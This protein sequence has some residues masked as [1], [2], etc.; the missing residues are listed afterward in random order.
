MS[1]MDM[2]RPEIALRE[3]QRVL[4]PGGLVQFSIVHPCFGPPYRKLLRDADRRP[5]ALE[6]G[7]Y[8]DTEDRI[9]EWI[10]GETPPEVRAGL[11]RFRVPLFHKPISFWFNAIVDAGLSIERVEEPAAS[12]ELAKQY[13]SMADTRI[14]A[15]TLHVR[16]RKPW[17]SSSTANSCPSNS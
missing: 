10:F 4:R 7:R 3:A 12:A 13:P 5:Y 14:V 1:L 11:R 6:V 9:D 17:D 16:C 15:Y 2:P 8:F